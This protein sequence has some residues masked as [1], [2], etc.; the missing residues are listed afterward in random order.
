M[1]STATVVLC[2]SCGAR[3][4][5]DNH[6]TICSP[7]QRTEI[8]NS[9]RRNACLSREATRIKAAFDSY[10]LYGVAEQLG[11]T[12][13]EALHVLLSARLVPGVSARRQTLLE[14]LVALRDRSH[15]DAA[16][17]LHISRWTVATYRSLLG[18]ERASDA[19]RTCSRSV[20]PA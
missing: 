20:R 19:S 8:E 3:L 6:G 4:A 16:D 5:R 17:A 1:L 18:I 14:Q 2:A 12:P 15:V 11:C 13:V 7:C 9:A 10:G